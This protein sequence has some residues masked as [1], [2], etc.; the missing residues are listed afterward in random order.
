M[1]FGK[2]INRYY[3]RY[4]HLLILGLLSL[5]TVDSMQLVIPKLYRMV[6]NGMNTGMVEVK[7]VTVPFTVDILLDNICMPMVG[8]ILAM[9]ICRLNCR[10]GFLRSFHAKKISVLF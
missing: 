10:T 1:I 9:V 4:A 2:H 6:I 3:F 8:V 5:V 7:G